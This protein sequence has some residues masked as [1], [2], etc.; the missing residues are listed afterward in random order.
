MKVKELRKI[1]KEVLQEELTAISSPDVSNLLKRAKEAVDAGKEVTVD[2][3]KIIKVV[4]GA[5]AFFP[6]GGGPSLRIRNYMSTPEKIVIDGVPSS[7][8]KKVA[9]QTSR[10][11]SGLPP[12]AT[13]MGYGGTG[14]GKFGQFYAGD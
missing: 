11:A 7:K 1:I 9:I 4:P 14:Y 2:G 3:V 13:S 8:F 12:G 5:G 6:E 10:G